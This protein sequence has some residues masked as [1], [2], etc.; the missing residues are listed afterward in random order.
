MKRLLFL[1]VGLCAYTG[2]NAQSLQEFANSW[3]YEKISYDEYFT[4]ILTL[5][6]KNVS[7]KT[8]TTIELA[9]TYNG[10][11]Y[12]P[13]NFTNPDPICRRTIQT[14]IAPGSTKTLTSTLDKDP[15]GNKPKGLHLVK[16]R[17]SDGSICDK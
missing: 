6:F 3:T 15:Y 16:L 10:Y 12:N 8:I 13:N 4:P 5:H 11:D 2:A 9:V 7:N 17:Y 14:N 1:I